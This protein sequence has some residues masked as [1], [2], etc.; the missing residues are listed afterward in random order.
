MERCVLSSY[1]KLRGVHACPF[2]L[3]MTT[4]DRQILNNIKDYV[5]IGTSTKKHTDDERSLLKSVLSIC[6]GGENIEWDTENSVNTVCEL[7]GVGKTTVY[8]HRKGTNLTK[9]ASRKRRS[10]ALNQQPWWDHASAVMDTFWEENCDEVPDADN[11]AELHD[12]SDKLNHRYDPLPDKRDVT[13][14]VCVGMYGLELIYYI[15]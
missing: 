2:T 5:R 10:D 8:R 12:F 4:I 6:I 11:P 15:S 3:E 9:P 13:Q 1:V 7:L 14:R